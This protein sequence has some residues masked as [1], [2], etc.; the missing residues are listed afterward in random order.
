MDRN[1]FVSGV[2]WYLKN[3]DII[4][5]ADTV[6]DKCEA[7]RQEIVNTLKA[8]NEDV[9]GSKKRIGNLQGD[10][11]EYYFAR[12]FNLKAKASGSPYRAE[13]LR[14]NELGSVD[15]IIYKMDAKGNAV[16]GSASTYSLKYYKSGSGAAS[17]QARTFGSE[18]RST[19]AQKIKK[20]PSITIESYTFDDYL[21]ERKLD[22]KGI[23]ENTLLYG[24]QSR[25]I[26]KA[27]ITSARKYLQKMIA[28]ETDP[29]RRKNLENVLKLLTDVLNSPDGKV[30]DIMLTRGRSE[31]IAMAA[32]KGGLDLNKLGIGVEDVLT[33]RIIWEKSL[34]TGYLSGAITLAIE[35]APQLIDLIQQLFEKGILD[36]NSF[37][38]MGALT[39]SASSF[40]LG[41][42]TSVFTFHATRTVLL[43]SITPEMISFAVMTCYTSISTIIKGC[44]DS[45]PKN[46][47]AEQ[48]IQNAY[49]LTW[50]YVGTSIVGSKIQ[51]GLT[52]AFEIVLK[53]LSKSVIPIFSTMI[54]S[55][56][57]A[58][59][60]GISYQLIKNVG[61][62]LC[63]ENGYTFFGLVK[64]DY[65]IPKQIYELLIS[66]S[67]KSDPIK[68]DNIH[69]DPINTDVITEPS[70]AFGERIFKLLMERQ[71]IKLNQIAYTII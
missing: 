53:S 10:M 51:M 62:S 29:S 68:P 3:I 34:Q 59:I 47:V 70:I 50:S 8:L 39:D 58:V 40:L 16:S 52:K 24:N 57:G 2:D 71:V 4:I 14:S 23:D 36:L 46:V 33:N 9:K 67:I 27:K 35:L 32:R 15:I 45:L 20:D 64:Q 28:K 61:I 37:D 48:L 43:K 44:R 13:V 11:A 5:G 55:L 18:Y 12:I 7:V 42:L 31:K 6:S 17:Q 38:V 22:N 63:V 56:I 21:K 1:E 65:T 49:V 19:L 69:L 54:G 25:L 60:G 30:G 26:P 41:T 66:D